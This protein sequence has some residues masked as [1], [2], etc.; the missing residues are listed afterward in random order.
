MTHPRREDLWNLLTMF[1]GMGYMALFVFAV[2]WARLLLSV[3]EEALTSR[4]RPSHKCVHPLPSPSIDTRL[5][6]HDYPD[7]KDSLPRRLP[8]GP[9]GR[10]RKNVCTR[11][12]KALSVGCG[13][14][15]TT[16]NARGI[17]DSSPL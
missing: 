7:A 1:N 16:A 11:K 17:L 12:G 14:R 6:F 5:G 8:V 3:F 9:K 10:G 4:K 13:T 15:L 2:I